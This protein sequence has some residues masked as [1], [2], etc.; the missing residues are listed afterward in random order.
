MNSG[1]SSSNM[2]LLLSANSERIQVRIK[3][4]L[5]NSLASNGSKQVLS[6]CT[7]PCLGGDSCSANL[8]RYC[9][10]LIRRI[11]SRCKMRNCADVSS[12][13]VNSCS[14]S[15]FKSRGV[16][17]TIVV[18][19]AILM[20]VALVLPNHVVHGTV[21]RNNNSRRNNS[22]R[23][24]KFCKNN[25][26]K[27]SSKKFSKN[28]SSKKFSNK[29]NNFSNKKDSH[30]FWCFAR[31]TI[32]TKPGP[33]QRF[34]FFPTFTFLRYHGICGR[35]GWGGNH[36]RVEVCSV[37]SGGG[38]KGRLSFSRV[39]FFISKFASNSMPSCRTSTLLVTV[40]LGNVDSDRVSGLALYV[41]R[42]N[43][44]GSVDGVSNISYSGRSANNINSGASLVITPVTTDY[45]LGIT[46][47]DNENLNRANNAISGLRSVPN[48]GATVT[49]SDFFGRMGGVKVSLVNRAKG[50]TPTSG[51]LCTLESMATA[52]SSETLVS[53][54]VV[55]GGLTTNSGGVILSIGY[56]DNT[57]V[58]GRGSTTTLTGAVMN[59]NGDYNEGV[60]TIVAGV[61]RPLNEGIKGTLR[62]VRTISILHN[63]NSGDLHRLSICLT[64]GVL[65]LS[66]QESVSR[67]VVRTAGTLSDNETFSGFHR[68]IRTRNKSISCVGSADLFGG[69]GYI[70]SVLSPYSKCVFSTSAKGVNRTTI[71][72]NTN[73]RGGSSGVS[74]TTKVMLHGGANREIGGNSTLTALCASYRTETSD[75]RGL[76]LGTVGVTSGPPRGGGLV[77][78]AVGWCFPLPISSGATVSQRARCNEQGQKSFCTRGVRC[79][80]GQQQGNES[81]HNGLRH[82]PGWRYH[83][84]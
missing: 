3:G 45:N 67:Y 69:S 70:H 46:G 49:D 23:N 62:I 28:S 57:F 50:L 38:R 60:V 11:C 84:F 8:H 39:G 24:N 30:K 29:N 35:L 25:F 9:G 77:C 5:R 55:D 83:N 40:Y 65:S 19:V 53:T 17:L 21:C 72:L 73:E 31:G 68:L 66:F 74:V 13:S 10:G 64:T 79:G 56:K 44:V 78:N 18:V 26:N 22:C 41:T 36:N 12:A 43:S 81:C 14:S 37:V 75:T 82:S 20:L 4:N 63:G 47:V 54:D 48:C 61:S 71:V 34:L 58:G 76:C 6:S 15:N 42:S 32:K 51:G 27:R 33:F 80:C 7:I 52:I 1:S 2:L 16:S 59:V